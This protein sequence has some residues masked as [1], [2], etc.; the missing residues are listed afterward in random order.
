V[1]VTN[2]R[3]L[4][5]L[6]VDLISMGFAIHL[7]WVDFSYLGY[8]SPLE[9]EFLGER[10]ILT[11]FLAISLVALAHS[12][13]LN[14]IT[15]DSK[16]AHRGGIFAALSMIMIIAT[17]FVLWPTGTTGFFLSILI[18]LILLII[19][20]LSFSRKITRTLQRYSLH[21]LIVFLAAT[22]PYAILFNSISTIASVIFIVNI[23]LGTIV[24][25]ITINKTLFPFPFDVLIVLSVPYISF[26][27]VPGG[28]IMGIQL[29]SLGAI[30]LS[31]LYNTFLLLFIVNETR[32]LQLLRKMITDNIPIY[33]MIVQSPSSISEIEQTVSIS[34]NQLGDLLEKYIDEELIERVGE[35]YRTRGMNNFQRLTI[36][37]NLMAD[38]SDFV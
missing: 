26:L 18:S 15:K 9:L 37:Q 13:Y 17:W 25:W 1:R 20:A 30:L 24:L 28:I 16:I 36:Y 21:G 7:S 29:D 5:L 31:F 8:Q 14:G 6:I 4:S 32:K 27:L 3:T 33:L 35:M 23:T 10:T 11:V 34:K 12:F 2:P 38:T 19:G 22:L